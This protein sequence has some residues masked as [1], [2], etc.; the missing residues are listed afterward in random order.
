ML[1][2]GISGSILSFSSQRLGSETNPSPRSLDRFGLVP[3]GECSGHVA[4]SRSR[5]IR[6]FAKEKNQTT[7]SSL[8]TPQRGWLAAAWATESK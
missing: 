8:K 2:G 5:Y 1:I 4:G 7:M 3:N 6:Y